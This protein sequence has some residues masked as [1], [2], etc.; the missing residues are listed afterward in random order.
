[1]KIALNLSPEGRVLSACKILAGQ[2]YNNMPQV[3]KLPEGD[4]YEYLYVNNEF[5]H[6][7]LEVEEVVIPSQLDILEA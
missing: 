3:T 6:Q 4:L 1:M 5:V 2:K 7:P